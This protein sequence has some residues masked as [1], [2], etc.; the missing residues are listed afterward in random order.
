M[1]LFVDE[2]QDIQDPFMPLLRYVKLAAD[3]DDA[4][5]WLNLIV[6]SAHRTDGMMQYFSRDENVDRYKFDSVRARTST[7]SR[8]CTAGLQGPT[9]RVPS[10]INKY[11]R[12]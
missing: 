8:C 9:L 6:I 7:S 11:H 2:A 1:R 10:V 5:D 3:H 4:L 12:C